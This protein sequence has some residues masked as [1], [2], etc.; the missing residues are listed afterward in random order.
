MSNVG[1]R[2]IMACIGLTLLTSSLLL[3]RQLGSVGVLLIAAP[4]ALILQL[5]DLLPSPKP[6]HPSV[7]TMRVSLILMGGALPMIGGVLYLVDADTR[8]WFQSAHA[9]RTAI[10]YVVLLALLLIGSLRPGTNRDEK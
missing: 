2:V 3:A 7:E 8:E 6:R 9:V 1:K 4:L 5:R 10:A